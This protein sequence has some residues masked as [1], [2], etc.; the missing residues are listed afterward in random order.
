MVDLK[1][2]ER[3]LDLALSKETK[4]SL[5]NWL[6]NLRKKRKPKCCNECISKIKDSLNRK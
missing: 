5:T 2:L 3:R 4:E 1:E 6:T